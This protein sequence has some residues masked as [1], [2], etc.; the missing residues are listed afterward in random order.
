M[1]LS[2]IR[3]KLLKNIQSLSK[4]PLAKSEFHGKQ[5]AIF[6]ALLEEI[7][8]ILG[9]SD[10]KET[11]EIAQ[12]SKTPLSSGYYFK[13]H[14]SMLAQIN[15]ALTKALTQ[16]NQLL[17]ANPHMIDTTKVITGPHSCSIIDLAPS[18]PEER[19]FFIVDMIIRGKGNPHHEKLFEL[20]KQKKLEI[21]LASPFLPKTTQQISTLFSLTTPEGAAQLHK[22]RARVHDVLVSTQ[23]GR[24]ASFGR[25]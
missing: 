4:P 16:S 17:F 25:K 2:A 21:D 24:T 9:F 15:G 6:A 11:K 1:K 3:H 10:T 7:D 22:H 13:T 5:K 18:N 8:A 12:E 20:S 14:A 23:S 19:A